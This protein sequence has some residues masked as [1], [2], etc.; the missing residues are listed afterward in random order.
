MVTNPLAVPV[1]WTGSAD[2]PWISVNPISF[3]L[4]AG[5]TQA[6]Q[7]TADVSAEPKNDWIMGALTF[8]PD[9]TSTVAAHFPVTVIPSTGVFPTEVTINTRRNTGSQDVTDLMALEITDLSTVLHGLTKADQTV[10]YLPQD[11]ANGEVYDDPSDGA[12]WIMTTVGPGTVRLVAEIIE[13]EASDVDLFVGLDLNGDMTPQENEQVCSSATAIALEK[14]DISNPAEGEYWILFQN[15]TS[16]SVGAT[17]RIVLASA[18]VAGD[19]GNWMV[20]GPSAVTELDPFDLTITWDL[21]DAMA[22]DRYYG[23]FDFGP[24]PAH[25]DIIG[26][27]AVD[28]I[29]LPDDVTK[30]ASPSDGVQAGDTVTF[31]VSINPN[32]TPTDLNYSVIDAIPAGTTLVPG[33]ISVSDGTFGVVGNYIYWNVDRMKP[34]FGYNI[35]TNASDPM[36]DTPFGGYVNLQAFSIFPQASIT[37]DTQAWT[38]FTS[39]DP[40]NFYGQAYTGASFTDDGF[41]IFNPSSNYGG[42]PWTAQTIPDTALPNNLLAAL[43]DD[44]EIFYSPPPTNTGVSLATAGANIFVIEYDNIEFY[45]GSADN[46][47]FEIV[48]SRAVDDLPGAYEYV[49]AYDNLNGDLSGDAVTIGVENATGTAGNAL[50]N[51]GDVSGVI[52]NGFMV[53]F[54]YVAQGATP[55]TMTYQVTVDS[56]V[57]L[58]STLTN[59]VSSVTN[60]PG[61][62]VAT[63]DFNLRI[64][65]YTFMPFIGKE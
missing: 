46:F 16:S 51:A 61:D 8:T 6:I 20:D 30:S 1:T 40:I 54:D 49:V 59:V 10:A 19:Q 33:S 58:G 37:G 38:A 4:P 24:D 7:V 32:V 31:T 11:S 48:G 2:Q 35:T 14:C 34:T 41:M 21:M 52:S 25:P 44:F 63:L 28:L 29:R 3:T 55:V 47:D 64:G 15:W 39:G 60:N 56:G 5:G 62:K 12:T 65:W 50:V 13:S 22:G 26:R 43:W 17:D 42:S 23:A 53:C 57:P 18:V 45:N 9:V 27:I 36:C